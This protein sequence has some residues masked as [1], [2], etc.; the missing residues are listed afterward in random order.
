[1][2]YKKDKINNKINKQKNKNPIKLIKITKIS[3][4]IPNQ[5]K[6]KPIKDNIHVIIK[7]FNKKLKYN[8][9]KS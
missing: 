2:L 7:K 3:L 4:I 1:M 6:N 9:R 8:K 5:K